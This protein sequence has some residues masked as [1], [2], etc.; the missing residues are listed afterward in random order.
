MYA[1][2][3]DHPSTREL[4]SRRLIEEG[5]ATQGD[6]EGWIGEFDAFLDSEFDA[7]K[8]Y[9]ADKADW[10]DGKWSHMHLAEGDERRGD[11]AVADQ[12]LRDI[13]LKI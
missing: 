5:V 1:K 9:K 13:G 4:Y 3:K 11:T 7:G 8:V 6:I 12:R 10:L 2:I